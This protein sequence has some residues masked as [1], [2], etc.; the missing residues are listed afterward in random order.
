MLLAAGRGERMRPLTQ[1]TPKPMLQL[2]GKPIIQW[3]IEGLAHVGCRHIV[4]NHA[5]LGGVVEAGLGLGTQWQISMSYS[6]EQQALE[7][8]GGIAFAL[9][10][11]GDAPFFVANGDVATD[12]PMAKIAA[13]LTNW[14]PRQ[15]AHLVLVPNPAHHQQGDFSLNTAGLVLNQGE[16]MRTFS[17][18]GI[19]HPSL[20]KSIQAGQLARL[21]P[22]LRQAIQE[23]R[24]TGELY[25][26]FW[27]DV[28]TPERLAELNLEFLVRPSHYSNLSASHRPLQPL[29][30]SSKFHE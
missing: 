17:G 19:Y 30:W 14:Q 24:V 21:A 20:F 11:L 26:G 12:W 15:L 6:A 29:N 13:I 2:A 18:L 23:Q 4:I 10:K 28:G 5:W 16:V 22:L 9:P 1:I 8:A 27:Q 7:T 25:R 3:L